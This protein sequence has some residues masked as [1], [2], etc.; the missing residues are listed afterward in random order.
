MNLRLRMAQSQ[1]STQMG[2][3][4]GVERRAGRYHGLKLLVDGPLDACLPETISLLRRLKRIGLGWV[5]LSLATKRVLMVILLVHCK[6][7]SRGP[8]TIPQG[9]YTIPLL[10]RQKARGGH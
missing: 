4:R 7:L 9:S 1:W 8:Q 2:Q 6:C 5:F 10:A 3:G